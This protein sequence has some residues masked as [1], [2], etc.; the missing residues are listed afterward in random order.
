MQEKLKEKYHLQSHHV[1]GIQIRMAKAFQAGCQ[2][3]EID[4]FFLAAEAAVKTRTRQGHAQSVRDPGRNGSSSASQRL[5]PAMFF[6]ASD[7]PANYKL[8]VSHFGRD[9][10]LFTDNKIELRQQG[11]D[12]TNPGTEMTGRFIPSSI[13]WQNCGLT[14][15]QLLLLLL[16]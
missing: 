3:F 7:M 9:H 5:L 8:A 16:S 11:S 12:G 15:G 2:G 13:S 14:L 6:I 4:N 1:V 10:V